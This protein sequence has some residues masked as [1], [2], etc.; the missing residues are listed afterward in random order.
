MLRENGQIIGKAKVNS[1]KV[2]TLSMALPAD[3]GNASPGSRTQCASGGCG[4]P[5]RPLA[6]T[7]AELDA[8]L[9]TVLDRAFRGEL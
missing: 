4:P 5:K 9:P 8:M 2:K 7:A 3:P 1:A 6:E